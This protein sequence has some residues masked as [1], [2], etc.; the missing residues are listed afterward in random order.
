LLRGREQNVRLTLPKLPNLVLWLC[1]FEHLSLIAPGKS[2]LMV[3]RSCFFME[4]NIDKA[5]HVVKY[6]W[7]MPFSRRVRIH[8]D[9]KNVSL[10]PI[11]DGFYDQQWT[12]TD[13]S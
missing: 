4:N 6:G 13:F 11:I 12:S 8:N 9:S 5:S 10:N 2:P 7:H 3:Q 1:T